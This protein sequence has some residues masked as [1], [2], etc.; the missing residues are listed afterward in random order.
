M[1]YAG[2]QEKFG[3]LN[4]NMYTVKETNMLMIRSRINC[5]VRVLTQSIN[6][7]IN[8]LL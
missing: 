3:S 8:V 4:V 7:S 1:S 6:Q 2:C 5:H